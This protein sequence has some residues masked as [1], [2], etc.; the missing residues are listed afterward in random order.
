MA[1][2][3]DLIVPNIYLKGNEGIPSYVQGTIKSYSDAMFV[4]GR[5]S[6]SKTDHEDENRNFHVSRCSW[7]ELLLKVLHQS[8]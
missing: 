6:Q 7:P 8:R 5:G 4:V 1:S 2:E 3:Y